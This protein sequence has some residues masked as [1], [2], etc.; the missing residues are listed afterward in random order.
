MIVP[1][2]QERNSLMEYLLDQGI[3]VFPMYPAIVPMQGAYKSMGF[4]EEDFPVSASYAK[5]IINLPIYETLHE[6]EV[7][8]ICNT[9]I[10][11]YGQ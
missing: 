10:E 6:E 8:Y 5:R 1:S 7:H 2:E 3:S 11:F 9:V 4:R